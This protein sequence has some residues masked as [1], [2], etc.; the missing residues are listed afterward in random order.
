MKSFEYKSIRGD[1]LIGIEIKNYNYGEKEEWD[2]LVK[3]D[4]EKETGIATRVF[5]KYENRNDVD[6]TIK[7]SVSKATEFALNELG[8]DGWE[9]VSIENVTP[10]GFDMMKPA[11]DKIYHL[12]REKK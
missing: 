4:L 3:T 10:S 2:K 1:E 8:E 9:L 5:S 11:T 6:E 12:K 7:K